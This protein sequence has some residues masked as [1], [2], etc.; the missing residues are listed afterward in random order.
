MQ[1]LLYANLSNLVLSETL[2]GSAFLWPK[3]VAGKDLTLKLRKSIRIDG[4]NESADT[5]VLHAVK[6]SIGRVDARPTSGTYQLKIGNASESPGANVTASI[7]FDATAPQVK[8]A[9]DALTLLS[10]AGITTTVTL[11]D[12]TYTVRFSDDAAR[13]ITCVDNAL[14]PLS[15]VTVNVHEFDEAQVHDIRL[16]QAVVAQTTLFTEVDAAIPAVSRIIAGSTNSEILTSEIQKLYVP[17]DFSEGSSFILKRGFK[18]TAPIGMPTSAAEVQTA[19]AALADDDGVFAV[20]EIQNGVLITFGGSM[21]G[22]A[23]DLLE[24]DVLEGPPPSAQLQLATNTPGMAAIIRTV[25]ANGEVKLP[26]ELELQVVDENDEELIH[27]YAFLVELTFKRPVNMDA[28]S[29]AAA[30]NWNQPLSAHGYQAWSPTQVVI[31]QRAYTAAIGDGS[32]NPIT[33]NHNLD[34]ENLHVSVRENVGGG[35]LVKPSEYTIAFTSANALTIEFATTP[36]EDEFVI[37][38]STADQP[39]SFLDHEHPISEITGLET[40]LSALEE[41]VAALQAHAPTGSFSVTASESAVVLQTWP[42]ERFLELY[43]RRGDALAHDAYPSLRDIPSTVIPKNG[44]LLPA[45]HDASPDELPYPLEIDAAHIGKVFE[46]MEADAILLPG[47]LGRK[48]VTLPVGGMAAFDGS[49]WY[50]VAK[51]PNESLTSYYP[52]DFDRELFA[53]TVPQEM[54]PVG[55]TLKI[56]LG[57]EVMMLL[58]RVNSW[59]ALTAETKRTAALWTFVLEVGEVTQDA[60]PSTTGVNLEGITWDTEHP[61]IVQRIDITHIPGVHY[62]GL[63][64]ART[65]S[66]LTAKQIKYATTLAADNPITLAFPLAFRARLIGFDTQ[67]SVADPRGIIGLRGLNADNS[68]AN[69]INDARGIAQIIKS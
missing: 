55:H 3:L 37:S 30:V 53:F 52:T 1:A 68:Q 65:G 48:G 38:I 8:A 61:L 50:R 24:V 64:V 15:F 2:G 9:L 58:A 13:V 45:V 44:G 7:A 14:L 16:V 62:F 43:P 36:D 32:T 4:T 21:S 54:W 47:R 42:L 60:T 69:G 66:G 25:D 22:T 12:G 18:K 67:D 11:T 10:G 28:F 41:A 46:N 40:R 5:R 39:A 17:P 51:G 19:L 35:E 26:L 63:R 27:K 56:D 49:A 31:G 59:Q 34:R 23:Q 6:A 33:I 29:S 57:F 20:T